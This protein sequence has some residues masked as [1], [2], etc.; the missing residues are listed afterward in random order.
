VG[1]SAERARTPD[2]GEKHNAR[3]SY[4]QALSN[5]RMVTLDTHA[6]TLQRG[7]KLEPKLIEA[8]ELKTRLGHIA[9]R[10]RTQGERK[11][12]HARES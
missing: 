6:R 2:E 11:K 3:E 9:E 12:W 4:T 7:S 10:A 8:K 5:A 1:H